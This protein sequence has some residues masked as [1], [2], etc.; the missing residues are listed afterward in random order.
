MTYNYVYI[1]SMGVQGK[2]KLLDRDPHRTPLRLALSMINLSSSP[3]RVCIRCNLHIVF[4]TYAIYL[5]NGVTIRLVSLPSARASLVS[6]GW[7]NELD[8][9]KPWRLVLEVPRTPVRG[10]SSFMTSHRKKKEQVCQETFPSS[11]ALPRSYPKGR[12][13]MRSPGTSPGTF[14]TSLNVL[15]KTRSMFL[16]AQTFFP[17]GRST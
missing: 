8:I 17:T 7:I 14:N 13:S 10:P 1:I 6:F 16:S 12:L 15:T 4:V 2:T 5:I 3:R 11:L 9:P